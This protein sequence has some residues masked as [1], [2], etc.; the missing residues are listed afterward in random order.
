MKF[1]EICRLC[2][3]TKRLF[4]PLYNTPGNLQEKI[5]T[6]SSRVEV[7]V[8]DGLPAQV[9]QQCAEMVNTCY[10]FKLQCEKSDMTLRHYVSS[11][12]Q[13]EHEVEGCFRLQETENCAIDG[14]QN[15]N[16][17]NYI[18]ATAVSPLCE[19]NLTLDWGMTCKNLQC[20]IRQENCVSDLQ[21]KMSENES[22]SSVCL[23]DMS[24][25]NIQELPTVDKSFSDD[26][27][28]SSSAI[29]STPEF[30]HKEDTRRRLSS[31]KSKSKFCLT[32]PWGKEPRSLESYNTYVNT[33]KS[34]NKESESVQKQDVHSLGSGR[35][36]VTSTDVSHRLVSNIYIQQAVCY[37]NSSSYRKTFGNISRAKPHIT[38]PTKYHKCGVCGKSVQK[39][40]LH[41]K[42]HTG[43]K[44][45]QC[46]VCGQRFI[47]KGSLQKHN[48]LHTGERPYSCTLC[49]KTFRCKSDLNQHIKLH[50]G[51][52]HKCSICEKE[53]T[54]RQNLDSHVRTHTGEK[55]Y[56]CHT[57]GIHFTQ[58]GALTKHG[59]IHANDRPHQCSVCN[60]GFITQSALNLHFRTHTGEK[61]YTC[62]TCQK[63]FTDRGYFMRHLMIHS[64]E[65]SF[66]CS[67]CGK[68]FTQQ[69]SLKRHVRLHTGEKPFLC[70]LCGDNFA[71]KR[72]LKRHTERV[73]EGN[74]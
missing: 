25:R 9:C 51:D 10:N 1:S 74:K 56:L 6:I 8:G 72:D 68:A 26:S 14:K 47:Q 2:L 17:E 3:S 27:T 12:S 46:S 42:M 63:S 41:M 31:K 73:H 66:V 5:N 67:V 11:H 30:K 29:D 4:L 15:M 34:N 40:N 21:S 20:R 22:K 53:F 57:C 49:G 64:G 39:L 18:D 52:A 48:T 54:T 59:R 61:P 62:A 16:C 35:G 32:A 13:C 33:K 37:G 23:S 38:L 19:R 43:E 45:Y 65:R 70:V 44:P 7:I 58:K 55:P 69:I 28:A 60:K 71:L 24:V 36:N 50:T